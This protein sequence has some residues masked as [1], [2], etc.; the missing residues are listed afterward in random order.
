MFQNQHPCS[1]RN[2]NLNKVRNQISTDFEIPNL[3]SHPLSPRLEH[4]STYFFHSDPY[5]QVCS[6]TV[7]VFAVGGDVVAAVGGPVGGAVGA[8]APVFDVASLVAVV[9]YHS[10]LLDV[11]YHCIEVIQHVRLMLYC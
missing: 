1:H 4:R 11:R 6:H 5:Q 9:P 10:R 3:S 7:V 8:A 2:K